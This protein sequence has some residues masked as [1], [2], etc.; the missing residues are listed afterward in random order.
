MM[1][2]TDFEEAETG[3]AL[4]DKLRGSCT[5]TAVMLLNMCWVDKLTCM[6]QTSHNIGLH[7]VHH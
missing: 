4:H 3:V 1:D 2:K 7:P 5:C 6:W